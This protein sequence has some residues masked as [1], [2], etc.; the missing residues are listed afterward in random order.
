MNFKHYLIKQ[1]QNDEL[2]L[3]VTMHSIQSEIRHN[4]VRNNEVHLI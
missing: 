3:K 4:D 2:S 1:V